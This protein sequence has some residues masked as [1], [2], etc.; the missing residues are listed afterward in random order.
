M[1]TKIPYSFIP[2]N[3][4]KNKSQ[5]FSG[6][7]SKIEKSIPSL[8][9]NLEYIK[10]EI[11]AQ[12][13]TSMCIMSSLASFIIFNIIINIFLIALKFQKPFLLVFLISAALA[14]FI[15]TQQILYPK[16]LVQ[17]KTKD[18]ERNILSVLQDI[19]VQLN[20]GIPFF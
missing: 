13:Y 4:L 2:F 17:K 9:L 10:T 19:L 11:S 5:I 3:I 16:I 7:G 1:K 18:I 15:F 12:E 6:I 20:S 8:R 14:G